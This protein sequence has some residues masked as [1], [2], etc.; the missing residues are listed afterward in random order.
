MS[1]HQSEAATDAIATGTLTVGH[2]QKLEHQR[3]RAL[4]LALCLTIVLLSI[5]IYSLFWRDSMFPQFLEI[6]CAIVLLLLITH[7]ILTVYENARLVHE[8]EQRNAKTE[9]LRKATASLT[10][11]LEMEPLLTHIVTIGAAELGFDAVA[12]ILVEEYER[13]LDGQSC[14]LARAAT[15][16]TRQMGAW[17]ITGEMLPFCTALLGKKMEVIW[18]ESPAHTTT[19]VH[20]WH[21]GQNIAT[22]L[23]VPLR[24]KGK[25]QGSLAF[26][27]RTTRQFNPHECY[28]ANAFAQEAANAI[29]HAHLYELARANAL[30]SQ[31]MSNVAARLNSVVATGTGMG[32]EIH[33]LICTEGANALRADLAILYVHNADG[34]LISQAAFAS[35]SEFP[36]LTQ[37]WP[38]I[39]QDEHASLVP[40]HLQPSLIW[41]DQ[42]DASD[43]GT[44]GRSTICPITGL[45]TTEPEKQYTLIAAHPT[46][47]LLTEGVARS[48]SSR[49][50][51]M[52][53]TLVPLPVGSLRHPQHS[54]TLREALQHRKVHTAILA[55]LAIHQNP[56]GLLILARTHRP[57]VPQRPAFAPQDLAH[58]QDF[59]W[60]ASVAFTNARLYQQLHNAHSRMQELDQLKDQFIMTASHELRT[61]LTAVH[62]YLELLEHYASAI[63]SEQQQ[64]FLQRASRACEEL[65]LLLNNVMDASRLEI[66]AGIRPAHIEDVVVRE[67]IEHV[68]DLI[69]PQATQEHRSIQINIPAHLAVKADL[70]YLRQIIRNI[71]ANALKYSPSGSPLLF[72]ARSLFQEEASVI[73]SI[74]DRGKGIKPQDQARL[75]QRFM[76]LESDLNSTVRGSG[77]GL[78]ISRRLVEAMNGKIWIESSGVPGMGTTFHIQ[79]PLS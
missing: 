47:S 1:A 61:P 67:A 34:Q 22:S 59:A 68:I 15:S 70:T 6:L 32:N 14:L 52:R 29:E 33:Q 24:Y 41:V 42:P 77:L 76:R 54:L 44:H 71:S 11:V 55:P 10:S 38:G 51:S 43:P 50:H 64:D 56:I 17:R 16:E 9:L 78:Y 73:I 30:F 26:S 60:Q 31:A 66:E 65:V 12:L 46:V 45:I 58:A 63:T 25:M 57:G 62:G 4:A 20:Q 53:A 72:S 37:E 19:P 27:L 48:T 36:T 35:S 69:L 40:D 79:L 75:F 18:E 23:F 8:H 7:Y 28:L 49:R 74:T 21:R 5:T 2:V 39:S 13:P 3:Y